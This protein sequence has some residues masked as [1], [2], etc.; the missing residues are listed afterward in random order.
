MVPDGL[1]QR[2]C[3]VLGAPMEEYGV[4]GCCCCH[5]LSDKL[6]EC[7]KSF[8]QCLIVRAP[9]NRFAPTHRRMVNSF[10]LNGTKWKWNIN[11]ILSHTVSVQSIYSCLQH[12]RIW[13][14][15]CC[16]T[17]SLSVKVTIVVSYHFAGVHVITPSIREW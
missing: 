1:I 16:D 2:Y 5:S 7:V 9:L 3:C 8:H 11:F 15:M 4:C 12:F 6:D 17:S 10:I 14:C 13:H